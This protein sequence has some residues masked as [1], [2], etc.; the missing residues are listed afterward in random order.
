MQILL[1]LLVAVLTLAT[2]W[3]MGVTLLVGFVPW[4]IPLWA[5]ACV[6]VGNLTHAV[7]R[8]IDRRYPR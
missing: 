4:K 7:L 1:K 5:L 6:G 2:G 3:F 8:A